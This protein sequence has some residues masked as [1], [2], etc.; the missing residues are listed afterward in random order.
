MPLAVL[1]KKSARFW[2][3]HP[4]VVDLSLEERN[5]RFPNEIAF[6]TKNFPFRSALDVGC[7]TGFDPINYAGL[8]VPVVVGLDAT[9][10][11]LRLGKAREDMSLSQSHM[12]DWVQ[13]DAEHLPFRDKSFDF[14]SAMGSLH[15][16][17]ETN[18]AVKE[19]ERVAKKEIVLMLYNRWY[20][21]FWRLKNKGA[22]P[23]Y[24]NGA[25][26]V[27]F[28]TARQVRKLFSSLRIREL[29]S[30]G[31]TPTDFSFRRLGIRI[32]DSVGRNFLKWAWYAR[33]TR[34]ESIQ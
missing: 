7:G 3:T 19:M 26:I 34:E 25:P 23:I 28:Y 10:K 31:P 29:R 14:V 5:A 12:I 30:L 13:A 32:T 6:L 21:F 11:S 20:V 2:E 9:R 27:K 17:P 18:E 24:D 1:K 8:G 4:C 22:R 33:A 16:T 15:H